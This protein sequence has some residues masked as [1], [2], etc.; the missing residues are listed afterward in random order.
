ME[1]LRFGSRLRDLNDQTDR[2]ASGAQ[3]DDVIRAD[4][5]HGIRRR[6]LQHLVAA[7]VRR[8]QLR[9]R[10]FNRLVHA[11]GIRALRGRIFLHAL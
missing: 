10:A 8:I 2:P 5:P 4:D 3:Y 1:R 11:Q 7:A 9:H 6:V